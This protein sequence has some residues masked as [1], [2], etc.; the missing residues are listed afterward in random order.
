M[1]SDRKSPPPPR[2][3]GKSKPGTPE[4]DEPQVLEQGTDSAPPACV[5]C[6]NANDPSGAAGLAGD[7]STVAA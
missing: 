5:V 1:S 3:A 2:H 4:G 7:I 6:F